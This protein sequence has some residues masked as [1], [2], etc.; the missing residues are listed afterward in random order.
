ME[1]IELKE[2]PNNYM[3]CDY[4]I[5]ECGA[6]YCYITKVDCKES[7]FKERNGYCPIKST[8]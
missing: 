2:L 6:Y 7:F 3:E 8:D 5:R 1:Y 4:A